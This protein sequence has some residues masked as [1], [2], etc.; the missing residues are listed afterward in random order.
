VCPECRRASNWF[1][2][3]YLHVFIGNTNSHPLV[4]FK[5]TKNKWDLLAKEVVRAQI[6]SYWAHRRLEVPEIKWVQ[7]NNYNSI[8]SWMCIIGNFNDNIAGVNRSMLVFTPV[9]F[10]DKGEY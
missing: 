7:T 4:Q 8:H 5:E 9:L 1:I 10:G 2:T 3:A 6:S